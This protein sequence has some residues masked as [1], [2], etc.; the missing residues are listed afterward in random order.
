MAWGR[1]SLAEKVEDKIKV[2][3]KRSRA[4]IHIRAAQPSVKAHE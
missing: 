2:F 1:F 4:L 3:E